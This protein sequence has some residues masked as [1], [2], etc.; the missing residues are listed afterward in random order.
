MDVALAEGLLNEARLFGELC[1]TR[2]KQEGVAAFLEKR[3]PQF[4]NQ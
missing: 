3:H 2:D 1:E 4:T